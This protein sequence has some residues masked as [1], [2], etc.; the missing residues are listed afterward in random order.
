M[1]DY[2][3]YRVTAWVRDSD[4]EGILNEPGWA[5]M[6]MFRNSPGSDGQETTTVIQMRTECEECLAEALSFGG[7]N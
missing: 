5:L 4:L 6:E 2:K 7:R 3:A 1:S